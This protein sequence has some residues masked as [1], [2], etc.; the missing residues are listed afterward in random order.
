MRR[1]GIVLRLI[2]SVAFFC[3]SSFA[4]TEY[5]IVNNNNYISNTAILYRLDASTGILTKTAV[6]HDGGQGLPYGN[7]DFYQVEQAVTQNASCIFVFDTGTS[8]I[9]AFS[10]ASKYHRVGRY[11]NSSLI[12]IFDGGTLALSPNGKFLYASYSETEN[13]GAWKINS[14][15][16]LTF[17]TA[18]SL[19]GNGQVRATPN[20][21][22][23]LATG[24]GGVAQFAIDK[25]TG[26]L[27][28]LG[29]LVFRIGACARLGVCAPYG[30]DITK[31]N[32]YVVLSSLALTVDRQDAFPV[33]LAAR[34]T[35]TGL[36]HPRVWALRNSAGLVANFFALF[37]AAGYGGS[38]DLYF[39]TQG[40]SGVEPGVLT[41]SF[42]E[43]PLSFKVKN[44]T[45][46]NTPRGL[47]GNIAV[48]GNLMVIAE[49]PNQ[50]GV[51]RINSDGSL[52]LLSTTTVNEQ[53]EGLFSLSIFPNTR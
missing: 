21:K 8:D 26:N 29:T 50:I 33:A 47:E 28:Y 46:L 32:K 11:F 19:S 48:T 41:T 4:E 18:Y 40:Q 10:K 37:S 23:L 25:P 53:G 39:G 15:C 42:T 1:Q 24:L 7:N 34:I 51:F 49:Y 22:Y 38:G 27:T 2:A 31:D 5:V 52:T 45:M 16:T 6:L 36:A 9:A 43:R 12:A 20:G 35:S 3:L 30:F 13:L 17:L 14:D 44:A